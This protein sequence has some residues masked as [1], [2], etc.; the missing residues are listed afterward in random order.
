M[1]LG[2]THN[3]YSPSHL[4]MLMTHCAELHMTVLDAGDMIVLDIGDMIVLNAGDI[5]AR[6]GQAGT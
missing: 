3:L 1:T 4:L 6:A 5:R 2:G